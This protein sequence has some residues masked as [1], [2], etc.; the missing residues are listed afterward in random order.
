VCGWAVNPYCCRS[1]PQLRI[2]RPGRL[3]SMRCSDLTQFV[4]IQCFFALAIADRLLIDHAMSGDVKQWQGEVEA[5]DGRPELGPAAHLFE[6]S[7]AVFAAS[8]QLMIGDYHNFD[9][10]SYRILRNEFRRFYLWNEGFSTS[11]GGLDR[12]LS[13][14]KNLEATVLG[15]MVSWTKA[16]LKSRPELH[17]LRF[18]VPAQRMYG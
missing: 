6:A 14:S 13:S 5:Q 17:L 10:D 9:P 18:W 15:I 11:S 1:Q 12:I 2:L 16:V 4:S 7:T 3:K 8:L